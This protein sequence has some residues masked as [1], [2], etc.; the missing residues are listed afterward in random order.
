MLLKASR[1]HARHRARLLLCTCISSHYE[2]RRTK[3]AALAASFP[4]C[5][6]VAKGGCMQ[7][8][9]GQLLSSEFVASPRGISVGNFRDVEAVLMGAVPIV[10]DFPPLS[11]LWDNVPVLRVQGQWGSLTPA[12]LEQQLEHWLKNTDT[13]SISKA[14]LPYWLAQLRL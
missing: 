12:K 14:F 8:Y 6:G 11:T 5:D 7:N 13:Y 10:D 4:G 1:Q 3:L 9:V 2:N